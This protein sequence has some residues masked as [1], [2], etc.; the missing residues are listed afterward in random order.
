MKRLIG[1]FAIVVLVALVAVS[2]SFARTRT[3]LAGPQYTP[4]ELQAL[5]A[6]SN[7]SFAQ[8]RAILAGGGSEAG[9]GSGFHWGDAGVGAGAGSV[10]C[11]WPAASRLSSRECATSVARCITPSVRC[12][13][14]GPDARTSDRQP[15]GALLHRGQVRRI[16]RGKR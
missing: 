6:Y 12:C 7:A 16:G 8:K 9:D 15:A 14:C 1:T 4:Q 3:P 2:A 10:A 11:S 13:G 5:I